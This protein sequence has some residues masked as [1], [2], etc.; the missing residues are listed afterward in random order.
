MKRIYNFYRQPQ[1]AIIRFL[2]LQDLKTTGRKLSMA[3][4]ADNDEVKACVEAGIDLFVVGDDQIDDVRQIAPTHFTG[5]GRNGH[6]LISLRIF[7][8]MRLR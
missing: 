8:V 7:L 3:N 6:S 4:P 2:D 5:V 1:P